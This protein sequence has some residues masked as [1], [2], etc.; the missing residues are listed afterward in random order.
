MVE[1]LLIAK[2]ALPVFWQSS[3]PDAMS[4]VSKMTPSARP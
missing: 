3:W 2:L 1:A 4:Q